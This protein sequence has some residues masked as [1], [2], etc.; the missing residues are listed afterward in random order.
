MLIRENPWLGFAFDLTG[1]SQ[2][3]K[4]KAIRAARWGKELGE[5]L[6]AF[7]RNPVGVLVGPVALLLGFGLTWFWLRRRNRRSVADAVAVIVAALVWIASFGLVL[8]H[9]SL[10]RLEAYVIAVGISVACWFVFDRFNNNRGNA[11]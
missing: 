4:F 1:T 2:K 11:K 3:R 7:R 10:G 5:Y 9:T 8:E 6:E